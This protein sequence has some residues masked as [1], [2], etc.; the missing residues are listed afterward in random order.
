MVIGFLY[1]M[2]KGRYTK[3]GKEK[4]GQKLCSKMEKGVK[5][6]SHRPRLNKPLL[7]FSTQFSL[8]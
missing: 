3:A 5:E 7:F 6:P 1:G 8:N 2:E 4:K